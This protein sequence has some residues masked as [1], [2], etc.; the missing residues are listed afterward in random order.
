MVAFGLSKTKIISGLQCVK[1]LYLQVHQPKEAEIDE[2][3]ER[4]IQSGYRV[5]EVARGLH[6]EGRL[7]G[8]Q[9]AVADA[10]RQ[11][12]ELLQEP[13]D[14]VL[15][16]AAFQHVGVA[17]RTDVLSREHDRY[18]LTEVKASTQVKGYYYND[19]AIQRWVIEGA[20]YPLKSTIVSHIDDQFIYPGEGDYRG[21]FKKVDVTDEI[22]S[23]QEQV[24]AWINE[25]RKMLAGPVP[26]IE[27]G[28][29]CHDPFECEYQKYCCRSLAPQPEYPVTLLPRGGKMVQR[30]LDAGYADLMKVPESELETTRHKRVWRVTRTGNAE[31]DPQAA[32]L[33]R[34]LGYPRYFLDF[35]TAQFAVP[36]WAGTRPY[37]QLPFQWSCHIETEGGALAHK[38]YI[39]ASGEPPMR[40][41]SESL[42]S[43]LGVAGPVLVFGHFETRILKE[44]AGRYPDLEAQLVKIV[45]RITNLH[46]VADAHYYHRDMKGSW[47]LKSILPTIAPDLDYSRLDEVQDGGEAQSAY[48]EAIDPH[49]TPQRR[50][51]LINALREYC[52]LDTLALVRL[53][54]FLAVG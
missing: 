2:R 53:T 38:E 15:F 48:V 47:S 24:P 9:T 50:D 18:R 25:L 33:V 1:R 30:L 44:L 22:E 51:Q 19:V 14:R 37:E 26:T 3:A 45:R 41:F 13:G 36:I 5:Q 20:G 4:L 43:A 31:L 32:A 39:G 8:Y 11:T 35:E 28:A 16:E 23:L 17:V 7:I 21:L 27:M 29:Q 46:L 12:S 52:K 6:P 49:T 40:A 54:R 42:I 34:G 10:L